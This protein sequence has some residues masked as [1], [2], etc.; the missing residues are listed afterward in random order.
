MTALEPHGG[1]KVAASF[2]AVNPPNND[3]M[4]T[5]QLSPVSELKFW[6]RS[7]NS[8]YGLEKFKVGVSTTGTAPN[9]FTFISGPTPIEAPI[10]WTEYTYDLTQYTETPVYIGIN[11][12]SPDVFFFIVDDVIVKG[13]TD[14]DDP[15]VPAL[16]TALNIN[17]PNPFNPET[18]ISY[19]L[20]QGENVKIEV[21]NIKGQLVR[22][23]VNEEQA[24]GNHKVVWTGVDNNNRPVSSGVYFYKMTAGKYSSSKKMIL[25]K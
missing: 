11:C 16:K 21:Y 17:Y 24:A 2:A 8:A 18:T 1:S 12:V 5:P 3:W 4:I 15:T 19:S 9:N 7:Y 23:L 14:A 6:A 13:A 10:E 22:T 25:M 20:K